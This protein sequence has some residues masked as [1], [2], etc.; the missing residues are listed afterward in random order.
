MAFD[1]GRRTT[2]EWEVVIGAEVRAARIAA[3]LDQA[4]LAS[5]ADVSLGAVKSLEG[6]RGS[7]LRTLVRVVRA[8]G[9]SEWLETLA[10]AVTVSPLALLASR[11]QSSLPRQRVSHRRRTPPQER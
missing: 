9:R 10:P 1:P 11:R 6:G 8:L 4:Q 3:D 5:R 2:G 7:T